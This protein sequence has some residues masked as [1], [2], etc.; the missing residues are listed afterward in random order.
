MKYFLSDAPINIEL[1]ISQIE[2]VDTKILHRFNELGFICGQK[3][4][5]ICSPNRYNR[6]ICVRGVALALDAALCK[7]VVVID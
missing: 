1:I 4:K 7:K 5:V 2:E 6:L 3:I